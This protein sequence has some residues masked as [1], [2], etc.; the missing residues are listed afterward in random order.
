MGARATRRFG[1]VDARGGLRL[2]GLGLFLLAGA[3]LFDCEPLFVPAAT[4][5]VLAVGS[6]AWAVAGAFGARVDRSVGVR[7]AVEGEAVEV[8]LTARGGPLGLLGA[9]LV[10]PLIDEPRRLGFRRRARLRVQAR[11]ERRGRRELA[12]PALRF[13]DPLG[14]VTARVDGGGPPASVLVLPRVEPVLVA[15]RDE[16]GDGTGA[17]GRRSG[18]GAAEVELD[19]LRPAREGAS[20]ARIHWPSLARGAGLMERRLRPEADARPLVAL[21]ARLPAGDE[22]LDEAVRAAA[23]LTVHLARRGGCALLLPGDRRPVTLDADLH[24]WTA[25]H[26]RLALLEAGAG[27]L[28]AALSGRR[29][30]LLLVIAHVPARVPRLLVSSPSSRRILVAPGELAGRRAA[31]TVAGCHGY[32]LGSVAGERMAA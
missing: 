15:G 2:L 11:F 6:L 16:G 31:F 32:V 3:G 18:F 8:R 21:D 30:P 17:G 29:G 22:A 28:P 5:L 7:R 4:L 9:A 19:G 12:P 25:Q 24:G 14:L 13:G 20:A 26:V 1:Q 10:D 27:P 23:S